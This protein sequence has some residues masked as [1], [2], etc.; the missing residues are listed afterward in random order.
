MSPRARQ[1]E[2]FISYS[3]AADGALAAQLQRTLNR[4][5]LPSYKWWQWWPPRVFRDQTNL[6]AVGDLTG[7]IESALLSSDHLVLLASPLAAASPW[8][9]KEAA[10]WRARKPPGR[11]FLALTEGTLEW[12][13]ERSDFDPARTTALPPAL[14]GSFESE[15]LWVDFTRVREDAPFARDPIFLDGAASLAAGIRGV[16]KDAL[17]GEDVRQRRRA[18]QLAGGAIATVTLLAVAATIAAIYASIQR[19]H[20]N[21]RAR[22]AL[23]REYAAKAVSAL[24]SDPEQSVVLAARAATTAPTREAD[25][26]LRRALRTSRL[27]SVVDAGARVTDIDVAAAA[28]LVAAALGNGEV[29]TW[30]AQTRSPEGTF[31]VGREAAL[32]V[33]VSRD[34][35]RLLG[36]TQARALVWST[37]RAGRTP[38]SRF[39]TGRILAA[40]LSADGQLVA[41]GHHDGTL[42]LW[43]AATGAL[44][45]ELRPR[46]PPDPVTSVAFSVDGRLVAAAV[47]TRT[48]V[49]SV[50]RPIA[51]IVLRHESAVAAV[52]FSPDGA[53]VATG[54]EEGVARVWRLRTRT[55]GVLVGHAGKVTSLSFSP[56]GRSLVTGSVDETARIWDTQTRDATAELRGHGGLV[57]AASFGRDGETVAT[58]STDRTIRF[59]AVAADPVHVE[60]VAPTELRVND[61]AF[62]PTGKRLVTAGNDRTVRVWDLASGES[63]RN[64]VHGNEWVEAARFDSGAR[65]VVSAGDD[66]MVRIWDA[67]TGEPRGTLAAHGGRELYDVATSPD[68][69]LVVAG[70]ADGSA[71][72]W[73]WR[74]RKLVARLRTPAPV[75]SVAVSPDGAFVA[76]AGGRAVRIWR[77]GAF[78]RP[79]AV[80]RDRGRVEDNEFWSVAFSP[81]G[82]RIAAGDWSGWWSVWEVRTRELVAREKANVD[83]VADVAFSGNGAYLVTADWKGAAKVWTVPGGGLVTSTRTSARSL[84]AAAFAP[85]GR[86]VAVAGQGGRT[87]VFECAECRPLRELV[88]LAAGRVM[89]A[90]RAREQEAFRGCG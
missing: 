18:R 60:L 86:L 13:D 4:I 54:D 71:R 49:W 23:S 48:V 3:H 51:A 68:G 79:F 81:G 62:D 42:R 35:R 20:A 1:Y 75:R 16:D 64:I 46:G 65:V 53:H 41:T 50:D 55:S 61:V 27:R 84:E 72:V 7:E 34:G 8:V 2:A 21:E 70:G 31:R 25:S 66:G 15:P 32:N 22:L 80:L 39:G 52:A 5:A 47:G 73:R 14:Q 63:I 44:E 29:R 45:D 90:V 69:Q 56:D 74:D 85:H 57:V 87:T 82:K 37:A 77:T 24:D 10:I 9:D 89:P 28:P 76:V 6:A 26:A 58:G 36:A 17:I 40:A 38:L 30:N 59:W 19:D 67:A 11:L 78:G 88:C 12:D 33:S 83:T 43:R